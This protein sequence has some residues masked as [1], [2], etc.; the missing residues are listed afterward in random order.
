MADTKLSDLGKI[1][2]AK[3]GDLYVR[4]DDSAALTWNGNTWEPVGAEQEKRLDNIEKML[5]KIAD[6]LAIL[7]EPDPKRL[8][9]FKT[10][11]EAYNKY[12]FVDELC[13]KS[14]QENRD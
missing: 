5:E 11:Q 6:R 10:L 7:E 9:E 4:N 14:E 2:S 1:S 8:E 3:S 12:K 13:G